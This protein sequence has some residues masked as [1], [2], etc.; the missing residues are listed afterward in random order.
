MA[1]KK[2]FLSSFKIA[3]RGML[4]ASLSERNLKIQW[5]VA[6]IVVAAG[7]TLQ[8]TILEWCLL[9]L[10]MGAVL[11]AETMNTAI[12]SLVDLLEPDQHES[13]RK[14]KDFAAGSVLLISIAA[15]MI[16]LVI[17]GN[18]VLLLLKG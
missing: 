13:A 1:A 2:H 9:V 15:S 17:F 5:S 12:E 14:A 18:H 4:E 16:G 7:L 11:S 10:S 6:A 3:I 8:V